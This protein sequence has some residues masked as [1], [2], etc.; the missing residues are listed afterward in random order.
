MSKIIKIENI[1]PLLNLFISLYNSGSFPIEECNNVSIIYKKLKN[2]IILYTKT[3]IKYIYDTLIEV[4]NQVKKN[5]KIRELLLEIQKL[6]NNTTISNKIKR[7]KYNMINKKSKT[8][9]MNKL[10]I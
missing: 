6:Y 5:D 2:N 9:L 4:N 1:E 10:K 8:A 7:K 3:E